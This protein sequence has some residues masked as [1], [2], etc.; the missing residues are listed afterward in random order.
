MATEAVVIQDYATLVDRVRA[1][2][3]QRDSPRDAQRPP[4]LIS[5][6]KS[7]RARIEVEK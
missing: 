1:E 7:E 6:W 4:F 2:T 5:G 3:L